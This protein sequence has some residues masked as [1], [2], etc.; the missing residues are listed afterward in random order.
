MNQ[1]VLY[2]KQ[3][4]IVKMP[5]TLKAQGVD[6]NHFRATDSPNQKL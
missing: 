3:Q 5:V 2:G 6:S 1:I 4:K